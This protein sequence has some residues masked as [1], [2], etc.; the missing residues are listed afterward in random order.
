MDEEYKCGGVSHL[1]RGGL[2]ADAGIFVLQG[3]PTPIFGP[4]DI[5]QAHSEDEWVEIRQ[6]M[7]AAE[8]IT[9]TIVIYHNKMT[10]E[11]N[12]IGWK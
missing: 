5:L 7:R 10:Q 9:Q 6:V 4:G 11:L 1:L 2:R 12:Q 8:I 3:I